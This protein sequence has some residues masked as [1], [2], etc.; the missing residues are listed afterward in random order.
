M[1]NSIRTCVDRYLAG[2][3]IA[4]QSTMLDRDGYGFLS[5]GIV[6]DDVV[7]SHHNLAAEDSAQVNFTCVLP[8]SSSLILGFTIFNRQDV[9]VASASSADLGLK[10]PSGP[11]RIRIPLPLARI[12]SGDFRIEAALFDS[13]TGY[14]QGDHLASFSLVNTI[15]NRAGMLPRG[16]TL[17]EHP[18]SVTVI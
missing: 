18:W 7:D 15:S 13:A 11:C 8:T 1:F 2:N 6:K 10:L 4:L 9:G 16:A 3:K 12:P 5:V 14:V 17:I